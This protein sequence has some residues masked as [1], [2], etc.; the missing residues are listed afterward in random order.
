MEQDRQLARLPCVVG[1]AF[2]S[3]HRQHE[4]QCICGT[5]VDLLRQVEE[6]SVNHEKCLFW[7]NGMAGTGKSTI[8]RTVAR[9][10]HD[11]GRLGA[12]YFFSRAQVILLML[13]ALSV[14]WHIS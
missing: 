3:Y 8:A 9:T 10:F 14:P 7:L 4:P 5:R 1:A 13:T 2:N 6:W 12:S 11:Q